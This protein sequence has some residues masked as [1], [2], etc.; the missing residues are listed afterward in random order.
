MCSIGA[1]MAQ[2]SRIELRNGGLSVL[3]L[4][5]VVVVAQAVSLH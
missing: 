3:L 1:Y 5:A 4:L 2:A